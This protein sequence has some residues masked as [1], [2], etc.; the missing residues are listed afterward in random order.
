MT[1]VDVAAANESFQ[2]PLIVEYVDGH[3]WIVYEPFTYCSPRVCIVIPKGTVT[4][5]ASI[6]RALWRVLSPTDRHVGKPAVVHDRLYRE[7]SIQITR[8]QADNELREAMNCVG[9][10]WWKRQTVYWSV[11]VGGGK[12]FKARTV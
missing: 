4:D 10:P 3:D 9:A 11:R 5:F 7:P 6:P 12:S 1:P 8:A 2:S